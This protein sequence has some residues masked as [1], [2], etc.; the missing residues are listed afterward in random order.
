[1]L[2]RCWADVSSK[3]RHEK[4]EQYQAVAKSGP[5]LP[6]FSGPYAYR[7]EKFPYFRKKRGKITRAMG[8]VCRTSATSARSPVGSVHAIVNTG[9][10][11]LPMFAGEHRHAQ[12]SGE[13]MLGKANGTTLTCIRTRA[14]ESRDVFTGIRPSG[15]HG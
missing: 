9:E 12:E 3:H 10:F 13:M 7:S 2:G 4:A 11:E 5:M 8:D 15:R 6:M 14:I 1:M